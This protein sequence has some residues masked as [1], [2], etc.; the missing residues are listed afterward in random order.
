MN[1]D[2]KFETIMNQSLLVQS[3]RYQMGEPFHEEPKILQEQVM[4]TR[5]LDG[6]QAIICLDRKCSFETLIVVFDTL[7]MTTNVV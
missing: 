6:V 5:I 7:N 3:H 1:F 2:F 4:E